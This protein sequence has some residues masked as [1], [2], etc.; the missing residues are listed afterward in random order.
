MKVLLV[1]RLRGL[2]ERQP[3]GLDG[4]LR[5]AAGGPLSAPSSL[6][7]AEVA[8]AAERDSLKAQLLE[9]MVSGKGVLQGKTLVYL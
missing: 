4:E 2:A 5:T 3:E 8:A 9:L 6:P 1:D 7:S